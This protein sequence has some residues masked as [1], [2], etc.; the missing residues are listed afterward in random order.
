MVSSSIAEAGQAME[1]VSVVAQSPC[2]VIQLQIQSRED[3]ALWM[4]CMDAP[5]VNRDNIRVY[6]KRGHHRPF[7]GAISR[8]SGSPAKED[9]RKRER[10]TEG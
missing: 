5:S 8:V 6:L 4:S 7:G 2:T 10:G 9:E 1:S 3:L